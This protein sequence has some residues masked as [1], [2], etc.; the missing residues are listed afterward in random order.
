MIQSQINLIIYTDLIVLHVALITLRR[1]RTYTRQFTSRGTA[2]KD[3]KEQRIARRLFICSQTLMRD[4]RVFTS[5]S[6]YV[7]LKVCFVSVLFLF[8]V[9]LC[10]FQ[11]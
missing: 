3:A 4:G 7:V 1:L 11:L 2:R 9:G 10:C 6:I 5:V 8:V